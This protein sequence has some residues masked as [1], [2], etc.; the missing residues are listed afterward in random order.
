MTAA[1]W[2]PHESTSWTLIMAQHQSRNLLHFF[3]EK[4]SS[5]TT[6]R[7]FV[8]ETMNTFREVLG[9]TA[10][11][12]TAAETTKVESAM[13]EAV[14]AEELRSIHPARRVQAFE[15]L[16]GVVATSSD[17]KNSAA[18]FKETPEL[19]E[20][21]LHLLSLELDVI[22][23]RRRRAYAR[24]LFLKPSLKKDIGFKLMFL[25][26]DRY[27]V[28]AAARRM[29]RFFEEKLRLFGDDK[30]VRQLKLLDLST[31]DVSSLFNGAGHVLHKDRSGRLI[32]FVDYS[33]LDYADW[34]NIVRAICLVLLDLL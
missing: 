19:I 31:E 16:H 11:I 32:F 21:S 29:C 26:A 15:E 3:S 10:V 22:P 17:G 7:V 8:S 25:R 30:L 4:G 9:P 24:A 13:M 14:S 5:L 23:V 6:T 27:D 34:K 33:Y 12:T 1:S 20:T 28:P 2:V 18:S